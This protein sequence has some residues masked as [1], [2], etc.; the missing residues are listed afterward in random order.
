MLDIK[1]IRENEEIVRRKLESRGAA[2]NLDQLLS[3]DKRRREIIVQVESLKSERKT[4]SKDIGL[5]KK[6]GKDTDEIQARVREMGDQIT[7]FDTELADLQNQIDYVL[8]STPNLPH[9]STPVGANETANVVVK[10][11]GEIRT[12]DFEPKAHWD[13]GEELK[14][15]D[16][17]RGAKVTGSG[18]PLF[19]GRGARLE[20]ALINFMLDLQTTENGYLEIA[21]P[22]IVNGDS[23][24][25]TGQLPKFEED[26]YST[27]GGQFYLIPTAEVP[28]TNIYRNEIIDQPLPVKMTAYTPC[29]RKEAGAA[30]RDTR[31]LVRVHQ[32]D[33]VELVKYAHPEKS[34]EELELLLAD[35]ES[36]LK[37]LGL[38]YRVLELCTGDIGFGAAKCYDI[39]LWAPAQ[40]RWLEVSSCSNF[41]DFQARR[42][43]LRFRDE[44]GKVQLLHTLNG[45]GVALPRLVVA[46]L[47]NYQEADGSITIPEALRPYMGGMEKIASLA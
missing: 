9:D 30:G 21:P 46:I 34:Y 24:T 35:A 45:S 47:E 27:D 41:E 5:L 13:L 7:A 11:V 40:N 26:M 1:F 44:D 8:M 39:E 22:F 4:V 23:M 42:L 17:E 33:K 16:L 18:F 6:E 31:G 43:K 2:L 37:R 38:H 28:V 3:Q 29:F 20:R 19:T 25:G 12:F 14:L 10:T 36:V 15:F 32:F